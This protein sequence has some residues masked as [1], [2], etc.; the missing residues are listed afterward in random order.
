[1][2]ARL[3]QP[4][5][6]EPDRVFGIVVTPF[7]VGDFLEHL[8]RMIIPRGKAPIHNLL[9]DSFWLCDAN[10]SSFDDRAQEALG[11]D[12]ILSYKIPVA[13]QHAAE[14]LRPRA[15]YGAIDDDVTDLAGA[16]F[17]RLRWKA[18]E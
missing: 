15:V 1:D 5:R 16:K 8:E 18:Q 6:V 9:R 4:E 12:R 11:R 13:Y 2:H 14:V 7:V 3:A 17:L 10:V